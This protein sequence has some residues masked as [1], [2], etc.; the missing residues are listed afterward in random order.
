MSSTVSVT[1]S[2]NIAVVTIDNP[3]VKRTGLQLAQ[4]AA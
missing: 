3:P 4:T 1:R 2:D